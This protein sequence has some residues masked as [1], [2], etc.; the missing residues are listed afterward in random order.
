MAVAVVR[1]NPLIDLQVYLAGAERVLAGEPVY[2]QPHGAL[3]FTYPPFAALLVTPL[4]LVPSWL[5]WLLLPL[6]SCAALLVL[7][8]R[9]RPGTTHRWLVLAVSASLLLE[10]VWMTLHFGQVNLLLTA[11]V[12]LDLGGRDHRWRGAA[13][14][15]AAAVKLTPLVFAAYLVVT[16]QWRALRLMLAV[17]AGTVLVPLVALPEEGLTYWTRVLP[18]AGRIGAPW[19]A[20]NQS[21]M[22]VLARLGGE[23]WWVRP[24]WLVLAVVVV[25]AALGVARATHRR[26]DTLA[27][28]SAVGVA[29]LLASPV[30]WSHHW[31]WVVPM[32]VVLA[33]YAGRPAA[34]A[35]VAGFVVA[36]HLWLPRHDDLELAWTWEHGPGDLFVWLGLVW[37]AVVSWRL[38]S[39]PPAPQ[40]PAP[41]VVP[42]RR[43]DHPPESLHPAPTRSGPLAPSSVRPTSGGTRSRS[44]STGSTASAGRGRST[45]GAR[46]AL[47]RGPWR[48]P[49]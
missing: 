24:A 14:G 46:P 29:S 33:R 48:P 20:A 21:L 35:W 19:Y 6:L 3:P 43:R 40:E 22:G 38:R 41:T 34:L 13:T 32:S 15:L 18:D 37:L 5:P 31:V 28:V 1:D 16:G 26:G 49:A 47:P 44:S 2:A 11:L 25:L 36:P 9:S 45:P 8:T 42:W 12:L 30:S 27:A 17:L 10:P 39:G 4:A 23:A 7:W